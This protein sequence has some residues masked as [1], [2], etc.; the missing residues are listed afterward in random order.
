MK[1]EKKDYFILQIMIISLMLFVVAISGFIF[2]KNDNVDLAMSLQSPSLRHPFGTDNVGRDLLARSLMGLRLSLLLALIAQSICL[3]IGLAIGIIAAYYGGI[4][5][6]L[7]VLIQ[8]IFQAFPATIAML[9]MMMLLGNGIPSMMIALSI[10]GWIG[11]ARLV[12]SQVKVLKNHNFI[13]GEIV[14]GTPQWKI[15]VFHILPNIIRSVIP[16][17]TL[18]IGHAVLGI[19]SLSFLGFGVQPPKAEIG[20]MIQDGLGYVNNAP[21]MFLFPGLIL[22][23]YSI[24]FNVIG[25]SL[26]DRLNPKSSMNVSRM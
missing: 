3:C 21:W 13:K 23:A 16:M 11:Y 12:R 20:L 22:A 8:N 9:C 10:F 1:K 14:I 24:M 2:S 17:Y 7:F 4:F 25:D 18:M 26:Q 19:S 15:H 6:R 5:D